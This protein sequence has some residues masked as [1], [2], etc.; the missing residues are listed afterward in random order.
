MLSLVLLHKSK[1]N[2][3][4]PTIIYLKI[5]TLLFSFIISTVDTV[6]ETDQDISNI[7]FSSL[8]QK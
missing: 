4:I 1:L 8:I 5:I 6:M 7:E 3:N 2:N